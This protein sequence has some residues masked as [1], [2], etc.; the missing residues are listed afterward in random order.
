MFYRA[1]TVPARVLA[2]VGSLLISSSVMAQAWKQ[3]MTP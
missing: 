3:G 1:P 2:L